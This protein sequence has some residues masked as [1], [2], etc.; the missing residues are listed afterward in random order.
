MAKTRTTTIPAADLHEDSGP[1]LDAPEAAEAFAAE[2]QAQ[3][4]AVLREQVAQLQ[5]QLATAES[6]G[7]VLDYPKTLYRKH[8]VDSKHENGY[9]ARQCPD[10]EHRP[11][12]NPRE[13]KESP[14]EL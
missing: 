8:A 3:Q 5:R 14:A 10:E 1:G 11:T 13:W 2:V 4:V 9:E 6:G 12:F 7:P